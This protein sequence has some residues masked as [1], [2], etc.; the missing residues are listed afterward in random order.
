VTGA[1]GYL[2]SGDFGRN[3]DTTSHALSTN[4]TSNGGQD[5]CLDCGWSTDVDALI[6][7]GGPRPPRDFLPPTNAPQTPPINLPSGYSIRVGPPSEIYPNGY[8]RMMDAQG[9][10]VDPSTLRQPGAVT[11]PEFAARTHVEFPSRQALWRY[12][13]IQVLRMRAWGPRSEQ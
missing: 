5:M 10:I 7:T 4:H 1:F 12:T 8:W 2:F 13:L 11:K 9:N 3:V 6:E